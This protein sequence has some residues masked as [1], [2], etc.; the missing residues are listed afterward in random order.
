MPNGLIPRSKRSH[1]NIRTS[2]K[3]LISS[4]LF[5]LLLEDASVNLKIIIGRTT[6]L[7]LMILDKSLAEVSK[8]T[9]FA[10]RLQMLELEKRKKQPTSLQ[11]GYFLRQQGDA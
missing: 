6:Y 4:P 5:P 3:F 1:P 9:E 2:G 7:E 11:N 8:S 10:Q